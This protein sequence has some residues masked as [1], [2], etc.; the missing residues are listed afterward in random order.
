VCISVCVAAYNIANAPEGQKTQTGVKEG[1]TLGM[2][3]AGGHI[4][5]EIGAFGG[6]PGM[7]LGG[8]VGSVGGAMVGHGDIS[9]Q[10]SDNAMKQLDILDKANKENFV[11]W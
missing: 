6:A 11:G 7:V 9:K 1:S 10:N 5:A 2:A 4:G 3:M 8:L